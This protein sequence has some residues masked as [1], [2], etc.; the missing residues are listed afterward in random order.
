MVLGMSIATF[1][2]IH[3]LISL[4]GIGTGLIV[5]FGLLNG[6]LLSPW[7]GI[8]LLF[9]VLTSVT[10]FL[11]P[12]EKVTPGIILGVLSRSSWPSPCSLS[13]PSTSREA[14]VLPTSSP[15]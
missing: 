7:N 9:T 5:L 11:Y 6:K 3:V 1:T 15:P 4:I 8:F 13:T 12:F 10:G 2:I 14:G